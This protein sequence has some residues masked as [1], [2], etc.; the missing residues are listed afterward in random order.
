MKLFTILSSILLLLFSSFLILGVI[1]GSE[2]SIKI[3][4]S[5]EAPQVVIYR[6]LQDFD[7]YHQWCSNIRK[8]NYNP[9]TNT[10]ETIYVIND[11]PI[12]INEKVQAIQSEN[13]VLF[14]QA[15]EVKRSY[16]ENFS[17]EIR[18]YE[19]PDGTTEVIWQARYTVRP[20]TSKILNSLFL[21]SSIKNM[22]MRNAQ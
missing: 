3:S 5:I 4:V 19:L 17:N 9:D 2:T 1:S 18:L 6:V 7:N 13:I 14:T 22:L 10:R 15:E 11:R 21:K 16:L 20:M 12:T 8:S